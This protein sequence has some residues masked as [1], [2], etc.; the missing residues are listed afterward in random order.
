MGHIRFFCY[1]E[2]I[3]KCFY[4]PCRLQRN[5]DCI[6]ITQWGLRHSLPA[7]LCIQILLIFRS[8]IL[9]S[10][11]LYSLTAG[12]KRFNI[13]DL[14]IRRVPITTWPGKTAT[15]DVW[16]RRRRLW[17]GA[18]RR[19]GAA[20]RCR[21]R[22]TGT[23]R[24]RTPRKCWAGR[25]AARRIS[26]RCSAL[27]DATIVKK[28]ARNPIAGHRPSTT[29]WENANFVYCRPADAHYI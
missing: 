13:Q 23:A 20:P 1:D 28:N 29:K 19:R 27:L 25:S 14:G 8:T 10:R 6:L 12:N 5:A 9:R 18:A 15:L 21:S 26:S 3:K 4:I 11:K 24:S 22:S 7:T 2:D 16:L 17:R